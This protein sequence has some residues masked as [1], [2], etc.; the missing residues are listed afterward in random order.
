MNKIETMT[1]LNNYRFDR[2]LEMEGEKYLYINSD[3]LLKY[4][5]EQEKE[6]K[7]LQEEYRRACSIIEMKQS[8]INHLERAIVIYEE[9]TGAKI[10]ENMCY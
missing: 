10:F 9:E 3:V 4:M 7:E 5:K 1:E 8:Y 6:R 2:S